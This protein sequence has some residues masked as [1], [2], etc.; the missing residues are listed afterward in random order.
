MN[1]IIL[2]RYGGND[3]AYANLLNHEGTPEN[4]QIMRNRSRSSRS[5]KLSIHHFRNFMITL[6][7]PSLENPPFMDDLPR[8]THPFIGDFLLPRLSITHYEPGLCPGT[9]MTKMLTSQKN[10]WAVTGQYFGS[11]LWMIIMDDQC[12]LFYRIMDYG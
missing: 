5:E 11:A 2:L 12:G 3:N 1:T 7:Y 8:K 6:R 10:F 4:S 9:P